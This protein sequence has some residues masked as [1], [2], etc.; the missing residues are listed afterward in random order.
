MGPGFF[1][2]SARRVLALLLCG[3]AVLVRARRFVSKRGN[4]SGPVFIIFLGR[5]GVLEGSSPAARCPGLFII[6]RSEKY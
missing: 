1:L 3:A 4:G 6:F 2:T 5:A